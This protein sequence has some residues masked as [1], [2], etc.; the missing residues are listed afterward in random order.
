MKTWE[1]T[2]A[3]ITILVFGRS[4]RQEGSKL[5]QSQSKRPRRNKFVLSVLSRTSLTLNVDPK[6]DFLICL[7]AAHDCWKWFRSN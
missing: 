1:W 6:K 4:D 5:E 2:H 3:Q 7:Q